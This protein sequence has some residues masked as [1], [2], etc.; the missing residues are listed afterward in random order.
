[1]M[2]EIALVIIFALLIL[3]MLPAIVLCLVSFVVV[4]IQMAGIILISIG[5]ILKFLFS[6]FLRLGFFW[7]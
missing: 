1:M 6:P 3:G 5:K 2:V 4:V 7:R